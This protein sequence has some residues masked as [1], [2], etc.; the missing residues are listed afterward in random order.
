MVELP[1]GLAASEDPGPF[2]EDALLDGQVR[3]RQLRRG[4]RAGTDAVLLA[5]AIEPRVDETIVDVGAGVGAV[6]LIVAAR[7]RQA[8]VV[9]VDRD[10]V[11]LDLCRA[12]AEANGVAER[13]RVVEAD[14]LAPASARR[15]TGL[16]PSSADWVATNLPYLDP[17][18]ARRSPDERRAAAHALP[19]SD[20]LD[21]WLR[22]CT[23]L[24][25]PKGALALIFRTDGLNRC[26]ACLGRGL[27]GLRLRF[28]HPR[29][30][31]PAIRFVLTGV[32]GSR[33]PLTV[34]P[35]LV[36]HALGGRFT[37]EADALHRGEAV[38]FGS[39]KGA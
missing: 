27:G 5:A 16:T 33:A 19:T 23:D 12:N 18:R 13:A 36:L 1:P 9:L 6:G 10:P 11:L 31:K 39:E 24:L 32:K 34:A 2:T 38:L 21:A 14:V 4:H 3:L 28:V 17:A 35:P 22:A 8:R 20:S 29:P 25:R 7:A 26:L 30:D 15:Q 37:P